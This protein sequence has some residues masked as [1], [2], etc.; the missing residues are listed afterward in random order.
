MHENAERPPRLFF[1][2][3]GF[4]RPAGRPLA[5]DLLDLVLEELARLSGETHLHRSLAAY[6]T[7]KE[8][9]TGARP[10]PID[11]EDFAA[12][13]DYQHAFGLLGSD[14]W[15]AEGNRDQ[16]LLRWGIGRILYGLTP[17]V[18]E[19]PELYLRFAEQLRPRDLVVTFNYDLLL[20]Q[21][22]E[23]VGLPYRRFPCRYS[24]V[25]V[26]SSTVDSDADSGEVQILKPHGSIDWV[27]RAR[28]NRQLESMRA[29][30][31]ADGVRF[32]EE[33]DLLFG[34]KGCSSTRPLVEGKRPDGDPLANVEVITDLDAYYAKANVA[35]FHPPIVL[36]PS[37]AKQLYGTALRGLWEGLGVWGFGWSGF[38]LIGYSLPP[39]DPY[40]KQVIYQIVQS[41][42]MGLRDPGWRIGPMS[43]ICLIDR[44]VSEYEAEQLLMNYRFL[45]TEHTNWH[46]D[47]FDLDALKLIFAD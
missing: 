9:T 17:T 44:R 20:E 22:L 16:F 8:A 28:Y 29:V 43:P 11:V 40:T 45:P 5:R 27:D 3:A 34:P 36:A 25:G 37:E 33:H 42:V 4:S 13:L 14:T 19:L 7:Y 39:A 12:Y 23:G 47:G 31:G 41:Y 15:S 21:S 38:S 26:L 1:L 35:Y 6:L 10:D 32:S 2:G 46:L 18:G 30:Q 24:E